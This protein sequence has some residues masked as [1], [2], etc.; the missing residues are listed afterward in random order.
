MYLRDLQIQNYKSCADVALTLDKHL[1]ILAGENNTGKST[2]LD[3]LRLLTLPLDDRR[4]LFASVD[5][6]TH[7]S[8]ENTFRV[9][10]EFA[11][12]SDV[13]LGLN[14][15][16]ISNLEGTSI[17]YG[18]RY[19]PPQPGRR[20]WDTVFWAGTPE[21]GDPEPE[22]RHLIRHVYLPALR[23][24]Q[25][26]LASG[27]SDRIALIVR[28]LAGKTKVEALEEAAKSALGDL[29]KHE[30]L[31]D[32]NRSVQDG[33]TR[34]SEGV[35]PQTTALGFAEKKLE[36]LARDLRFRLS[37][38]GID[39]AELEESG[40]GYANLLYMAS[41]LAELTTASD[42]DLTLLL[43]EEPE[44]HLHPQLQLAVVRYLEDRA[45]ESQ[46]TIPSPG[47]PAGH[48]QVVLTTHSPNVTAAAS[49]S[50]TVVLTSVPAP[51]TPPPIVSIPADDHVAEQPG[52]APAEEQ[53]SLVKQRRAAPLPIRELNLAPAV[54]SKLDRYLDVTRSA[55]LFSRRT[56]L[57]EGVSEAV[58]LRTIGL[59]SVLP[60]EEAPLGPEADNEERTQQQAM[61]AQRRRARSRFRNTCI[62]PIDGVDFAPYVSLL[63][64]PY[65][66]RRLADTVVVVTDQDPTTPGDRKSKLESL[67]TT[68]GA[69]GALHVY[70]GDPTL[71]AALFPEN[72]ALL[73]KAFRLCHP[74]TKKWKEVSEK[75]E[76]ERPAALLALLSDTDTRKGEFAQVLA[77]LIGAGEP[78]VTPKYLSD[79]VRSISQ[80][81][82]DAE[83]TLE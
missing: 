60:R 63:L 42:A 41:I 17:R 79:A 45:R 22:A 9:S 24:A 13:Q 26:A 8:D 70:V 12:L 15:A 66:E 27:S 34:L 2:I 33:L 43:V 38:E 46:R 7:G 21:S 68:L 3:A 69:S 5:H 77:E 73:E 57:V 59:T 1:T 35:S 18:F 10:A 28:H 40:L 4:D 48:V 53:S 76:P 78:F 83:I 80:A 47:E 6:I 14:I 44:A 19:I 82:D 72:E 64:S 32:T 31:T 49:L 74:R 75:P 56:L 50:H 25:R 62:V 36:R 71:E 67:A 23:D 20:R 51:S 55:L 54:L 30:A 11:E 52:T 37:D 16:A 29:G 58:L 65:R 61:N 81:D 39:P